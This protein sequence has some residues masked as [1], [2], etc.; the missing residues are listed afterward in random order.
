MELGTGVGVCGM[1]GV[2]V[3]VLVGVGVGGI[4]GV[5]VGVLVG[6][7]AAVAVGIGVLV[8]TSVGGGVAVVGVGMPLQADKMSPREAVPLNLSKSRRLSLRFFILPAL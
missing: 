5:A 2:A 8:G 7:G 4:V 6:V 3:G 1:V